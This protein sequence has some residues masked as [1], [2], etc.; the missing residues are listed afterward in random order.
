MLAPG[1]SDALSMRSTAGKGGHPRGDDRCTEEGGWTVQNM[2][3]GGGPCERGESRAGGRG[4]MRVGGGRGDTWR[5]KMST[6]KLNCEV[7]SEQGKLW[8]KLNKKVHHVT[9]IRV[10]F[11]NFLN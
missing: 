8:K 2:A 1:I 10:K 3:T 11:H 9:S 4:G 7:K 5:D 6:L